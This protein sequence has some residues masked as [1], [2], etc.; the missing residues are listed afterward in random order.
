MSPPVR[1]VPMH[2]YMPSRAVGRVLVVAVFLVVK[3]PGTLS[4]ILR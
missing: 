2:W 1:R 4:R 3:R